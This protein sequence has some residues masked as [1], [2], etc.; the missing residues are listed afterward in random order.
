[1]ATGWI[2]IIPTMRFSGLIPFPPDASHLPH[3]NTGILDL[4]PSILTSFTPTTFPIYFVLMERDL[5]ADPVPSDIP[6]CN[7]GFWGP[8]PFPVTF[9]IV[10]L[11]FGSCSRSR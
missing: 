4:I 3:S 1:M 11:D 10:T 8:I 9:P 6:C 2:K 5:G 7:A